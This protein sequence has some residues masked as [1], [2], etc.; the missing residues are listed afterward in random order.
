MRFEWDEE[1]SRLNL[2]RHK[3][4]FE[5]A[6]LLFED[7]HAATIRDELHSDE[8]ERLITIGSL[9]NAL[10]LMAVHTSFDA[11]G[12]EVIRVISARNATPRE[13]EFYEAEKANQRAAARHRRARRHERE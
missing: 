12:E 4:A 3:V 7:P 8:E 5:T 11:D 13:R 1:K 6:V 9:G 2:I 10:V